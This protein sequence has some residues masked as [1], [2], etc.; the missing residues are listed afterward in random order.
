MHEL[1][2]D[3]LGEIDVRRNLDRVDDRGAIGRLGLSLGVGLCSCLLV[4]LLGSLEYLRHGL[5][6]GCHAVEVDRLR[7]RWRS[8]SEGH[9]DRLLNGLLRALAVERC[10]GV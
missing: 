4:L 6:V 10:H 5:I 8:Q 9:G 3:E 2:L 7:Y 1:E